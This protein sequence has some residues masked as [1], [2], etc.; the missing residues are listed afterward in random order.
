MALHVENK[1]L[2]ELG[3]KRLMPNNVAFASNRILM[4]ESDRLLRAAFA[5][6]ARIEFACL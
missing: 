1:C 6:R 5:D 4:I 2:I 3:C